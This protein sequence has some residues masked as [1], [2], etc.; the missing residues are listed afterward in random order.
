MND[1]EMNLC[2]KHPVHGVGPGELAP[3]QH[4]FRTRLQ[5]LVRGGLLNDVADQIAGLPQDWELDPGRG[6]AVERLRKWAKQDS[7]DPLRV[8]LTWDGTVL[9]PDGSDLTQRAV[10]MGDTP[11]GIAGELVVTGENRVKLASLLDAELRDPYAKCPT[12]GCGSPEDLDTTD[13]WG[14]TRLK[15]AGTDEIYRWYCT[16]TCVSNALARAGDE[17]AEADSRAELDGG[18]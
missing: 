3:L 11:N 8:R 4:E 5:R 2:Q 18:M 15:V 6:D 12:P 10:I 14:W 16:P 7:S 17:L 9:Y 13:V 1:H